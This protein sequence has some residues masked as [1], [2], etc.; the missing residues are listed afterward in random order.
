MENQDYGQ[1]GTNENK[2][3]RNR[4]DRGRGYREK[5]VKSFQ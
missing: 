3:G 1:H 2:G 5:K 4:K